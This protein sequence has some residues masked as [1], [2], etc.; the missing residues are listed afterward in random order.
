MPA[1]PQS[2]SEKEDSLDNT[3]DQHTEIKNDGDTHDTSE[4]GANLSDSQQQ[5]DGKEGE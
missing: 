1:N 3:D 5:H 2:P 4:Q